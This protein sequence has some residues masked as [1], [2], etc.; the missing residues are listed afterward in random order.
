MAS[1]SFPFPFPRRRAHPGHGGA[2]TDPAATRPGPSAGRALT[3]R[4]VALL[5]VVVA[6]LAA[7]W[8]WV[9]DS[10]FVAVQDVT[11]VGVEGP[12]AGAVRSALDSAARSMTTLHVQSAELR[13]AVAGYP[14]V[15]DLTATG[16]FPHAL[17]ITVEERPAVAG[18]RSAD[19]TIPVAADGTLLRG[20][21]AEGLPIVTVKTPPG[22]TVLT[23]KL[24]LAEVRILAAA[25]K[26]LRERVTKVFTGGRGIAVQ[27]SR[28]PVAAFG[29][30]ER[31]AAKWAA[32]AAVLASPAS[33]GGTLIDLGVP[34]RPAVA[35][36]EPAPDDPAAAVNGT[37]ADATEID[38]AQA[39]APPSGTPTPGSSGS[40]PAATAATTVT[41]PAAPAAA[42]TPT[43][44]P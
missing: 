30:A 44:T 4:I 16:D 22:G 38:G 2:T 34:E 37:P 13:A 23:D 6:V 18:L 24:A 21:D 15:K 36:L 12:Q 42:T 41:D 26:A 9:R 28:G 5:L 10:S 19:R 20:S 14:V 25:P 1:A 40:A 17:T 32:L 43:A 35:G 3:R 11:I 31:P 39:T 27:L 7:G 33:A 8:W 29:S